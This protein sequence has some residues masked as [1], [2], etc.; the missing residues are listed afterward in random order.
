[1]SK[2][3]TPT[4]VDVREGWKF[5]FF[6]ANIKKVLNERINL[7]EHEISETLKQLERE[8]GIDSKSF[9]GL[10][11]AVL[12]DDNHSTRTAYIKQLATHVISLT[13]LR[14]E[15]ARKHKGITDDIIYV[16]NAEMM[17]ELGL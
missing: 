4:V 8:V 6:G 14:D 11:V 15:L 2:E 12:D 17:K 10:L 9:A 13:A 7:L 5:G 3:N 16:L 1:M